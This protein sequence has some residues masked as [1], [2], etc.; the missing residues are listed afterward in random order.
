MYIFYFIICK[1]KGKNVDVFKKKLLK[2]YICNG[3]LYKNFLF[4]LLLFLFEEI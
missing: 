3:N 2:S 1:V 4:I